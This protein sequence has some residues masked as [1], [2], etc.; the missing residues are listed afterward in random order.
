[1]PEAQGHT[2]TSRYPAIGAALA[3]GLIIDALTLCDMRLQ[4]PCFRQPEAAWTGAI[5]RPLARASMYA[6]HSQ[7]VFPVMGLPHPQA[8][9]EVHPSLFD[10]NIR[11][12]C[13]NA[14][15]PRRSHGQGKQGT[16]GPRVLLVLP[17]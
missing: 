7:S 14:N 6:I 10:R 3:Y 17:R 2:W 13:V 9:D 16:V 4:S 5:S 15:R 11:R 12:N 1:M 8:L